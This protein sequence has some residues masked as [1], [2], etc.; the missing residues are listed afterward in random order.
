MLFCTWHYAQPPSGRAGHRTA[1]S[2]PRGIYV[3]KTSLL[4]SNQSD[5]CL[6]KLKSGNGSHETRLG[7]TGSGS[8]HETH[9]RHQDVCIGAG[10]VDRS[11][12]Y[13]KRPAQPVSAIKPLEGCGLIRIERRL[14]PPDCV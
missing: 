14:R 7:E 9:Q 2:W 5:V 11:C 4:Q 3:L 8:V 13:T 10:Q 1:R 12:Q 6:V